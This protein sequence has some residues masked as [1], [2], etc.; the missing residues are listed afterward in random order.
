M[1]KALFLFPPVVKTHVGLCRLELSL[2]HCQD[3]MLS[4]RKPSW[5]GLPRCLCKMVVLACSRA[6]LIAP[7]LAI[8][9]WSVPSLSLPRLRSHTARLHSSCGQDEV[10]ERGHIT[11]PFLKASQWVSVHLTATVIEQW[12]SKWVIRRQIISWHLATLKLLE[13]SCTP[14][15]SLMSR[16]GK[17]SGRESR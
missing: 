15:T 6:A 4:I 3:I 11:E 9:A 5:R 16:E 8:R 1:I 2:L 7:S 12:A 10:N 13:H 17:W 14:D